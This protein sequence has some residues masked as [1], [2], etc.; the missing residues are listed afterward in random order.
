MF[1]KK[2]HEKFWKLVEKNGLGNSIVSVRTRALKIEEAIGNP[3]RRDFPLLK[4][5]EVLMEARFNNAIG[6]AYTDMPTEFSG[7]LDQVVSLEIKSSRDRALYISVLNAVVRYFY[8]EVATIHC[9]NNEPEECAEEMADSINHKKYRKIGQIGL[10]PSIL[11]ALVNKFGEDNLMC[12]DLDE[13]NKG[14][15]KFGVPIL[16]GDL[17]N[18]EEIFK[19]SDI[20][21]CTGTTV[22][23]G[24][25]ESMLKLSEKYRIPIIFYGTTI[26][27]TAELMGLERLCFRSR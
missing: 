20:V 1:Y 27:G 6:Q 22:V 16:W 10:Q 11:E 3:D 26:A 14:I 9:K 12:A 13:D 21:L 19:G 23:N 17:E 5:K 24:S 7:T 15:I 4:G 25:I 18:T 2:L 8:P